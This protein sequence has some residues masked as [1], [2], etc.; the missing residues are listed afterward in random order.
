MVFEWRSN[1]GIEKPKQTDDSDTNTSLFHQL[2]TEHC[3][4][5]DRAKELE[6][7]TQNGSHQVE[8]IS[9]FHF[10]FHELIKLTCQAH[11]CRLM[12][13]FS[14]Q[15]CSSSSYSFLSRSPSLSISISIPL[16]IQLASCRYLSL[17][18]LICQH[19]SLAS[20]GTRYQTQYQA[21]N[22]FQ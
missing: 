19:Q 10:R 18:T 15:F 1:C 22:L 11:L 12:L 16:S 21:A 8:S 5:K 7:Q 14:F 4:M 13:S 6:R 3:L 9:E 20:F 2:E 17:W